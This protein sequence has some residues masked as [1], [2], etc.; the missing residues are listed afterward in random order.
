MEKIVEADNPP[1]RPSLSSKHRWF[2]RA[3]VLALGAIF[4][5]FVLPGDSVDLTRRFN[6]Y[7]VTLTQLLIYGI[8][9]VIT[10]FVSSTVKEWMSLILLPLGCLNVW[11]YSFDG[12]NAFHPHLSKILLQPD[13]REFARHILGACGVSMVAISIATL[14]FRPRR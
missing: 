5:G 8:V 1:L 4:V 14:I 13:L 6:Y 9:I 3:T 2:R 7:S 11:Y 12:A 10:S